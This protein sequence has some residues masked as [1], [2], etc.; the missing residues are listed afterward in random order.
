MSYYFQLNKFISQ[1]KSTDLGVGDY[2]KEYL[3][4]KV[5]VSFGKGNQAKIPWIAFLNQYNSVQHGIYPVYLLYKEQSILILAY[6]VSETNPPERDWI[7]SD[8]VTINEYFKQNNIGTPNRYGDSFVFRVYDVNK[9]L[10][11][12]TID[13]DLHEIIEI[14]NS[15]SLDNLILFRLKDKPEM[16]IDFTKLASIKTKP[17]LLLAGISGTGKSRLARILAYQ[18][19]NIESDRDSVKHPPSNFQ[20]V[21][22]KPNWHDSSELLGY[23]SRISGKD[24]YVVTDFMR[25]LVK[26]HQYPNTPFIVCLDEMNLAPVEHYFAEYLSAVETRRVLGDRIVSDSLISPEIFEKYHSR[27]DDDDSRNEF[28]K[29]LKVDDESLQGELLEKGLTIPD[30]LIVIGTVNMDETTHSFSRKVLDRAMTIEMNEINLAEGLIADNDVWSYPE[31]PIPAELILPEFTQGSEVYNELGEDGPKIIAYLEALN[32]CLL[33]T[34]F[35][36]AYRVRDDFL[37]YAYNYSKIE[38][39]PDDWLMQVLDDMTLMKVL[40]RIE[41]DEDKTIVLRDLETFLGGKKLDRSRKKVKEMNERRM[42][43]HF[44]SF[45]P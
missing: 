13:S 45:W 1:S 39:R 31:E 17:F 22:V 20:L 40:P 12:D 23:E 25:F 19:N 38:S 24:R 10:D 27:K 8:Q 37:L 42:K 41:G 26:A 6:G 43:S 44:T 32:F 3:G 15:S 2:E 18:F 9:S 21:K 4:L 16:I 5:K 29:D 11:R 7:I 33:G 36:I 30:N 34:P 28:W 35:Q 14:Y